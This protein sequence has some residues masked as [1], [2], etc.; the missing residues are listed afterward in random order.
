MIRVSIV[1]GATHDADSLS[2]L[3]PRVASLSLMDRGVTFEVLVIRQASTEDAVDIVRRSHAR[4]IRL[5]PGQGRSAGLRAAAAASTGTHIMIHDDAC[6]YDPGDYVRVIAELRRAGDAIVVYGS[7]YLQPSSGRF[8]GRIRLLPW[9]G[10]SWQAFFSDR[11]LSFA[12]WSAAGRFLTDPLAALRIF[13]VALFQSL[14]LEG[15]DADVDCEISAKVLARGIPIVEVPVYYQR[16]GA[17]RPSLRR[18]EWWR[19]VKA[20]YRY[21]RPHG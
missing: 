2:V 20:L 16:R 5:E 19:A 17:I 13:P 15:T 7:R 6:H 1:F 8:G 4:I 10:Q 3:L 14:N 21:S 18:G 12:S 11:S 9:R